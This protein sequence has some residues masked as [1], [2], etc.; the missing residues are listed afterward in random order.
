[1]DISSYKKILL[2]CSNLPHCLPGSPGVLQHLPNSTA[3]ETMGAWDGSGSAIL[4]SLPSLAHKFEAHQCCRGDGGNFLLSMTAATSYFCKLLHSRSSGIQMK[5]IHSSHLKAILQK[6]PQILSVVPYYL[7][8][9]CF[10]KMVQGSFF[11]CLSL[12][13]P[14]R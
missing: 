6:G 12:S 10:E 13:Q 14:H 4:Y 3:F 1:M 8:S 9:S 2:L 11:Q 7:T 5:N